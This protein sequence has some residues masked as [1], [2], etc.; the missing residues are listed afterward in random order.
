MDK[1]LDPESFDFE[2]A[3][4]ATL[5]WLRRPIEALRRYHDH[6]ALGLENIPNNGGF[7]LVVNHSLATYDG[8]LLGLAIHE[9][10]GRGLTALGDDR[11]FKTPVLAKLV[12]KCGIVP[13]SPENGLKLLAKGHAVAVAPGGM[14]E[15]LRP[16]TTESYT[17]R[18]EHR[19]GFVRLA[20]RA[21]V[22]IVLAACP[23][24]DELYDV[25]ENPL[26]KLAY[27]KLHLPLPMMSGLAG[28]LMP[29]PVKLL[30]VVGAPLKPPALEEGAFKAQVDTWHAHICEQMQHLMDRALLLRG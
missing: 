17:I 7:L 4:D 29:R 21:Q 14:R 2:P 23:A 27:K 1:R 30:H 5:E 24:A 16:T 18:W 22:P 9:F 10:T 25:Y 20:L 11:L 8:L 15:A 6:E 19:R 13:A 3:D 12:R 26:T 28:T